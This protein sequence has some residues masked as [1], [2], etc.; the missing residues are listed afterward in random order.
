MGEPQHSA[1]GD[2]LAVLLGDGGHRQ[3]EVGTEQAAREALAV[4][5]DLRQRVAEAPSPEEVERLRERVGTLDKVA[6]AHRALWRD[7]D[8]YVAQERG[9]IVEWMTGPE[10]V[11]LSMTGG[12]WAELIDNGEHHAE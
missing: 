3:A 1:V 2:L 9:D 10:R 4:V 7:G 11:D 5:H 8:T 6:S 12:E